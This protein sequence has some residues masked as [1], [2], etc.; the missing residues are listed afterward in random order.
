VKPLQVAVPVGVCARG[1]RTCVSA[2]ALRFILSGGGWQADAPGEA[3]HFHQHVRLRHARR[4]V[5]AQRAGDTWGQG[6]GVRRG[7]MTDAEHRDV[8]STKASAPSTPRPAT[9]TRLLP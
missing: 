2:T 4:F 9:S 6:I 7:C 3:V 1:V 5:V 8:L